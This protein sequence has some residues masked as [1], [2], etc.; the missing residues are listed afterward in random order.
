MASIVSSNDQ[1]ETA[2]ARSPV[3]LHSDAARLYLNGID[4]DFGVHVTTESMDEVFSYRLRHDGQIRDTIHHSFAGIGAP[5]LFIRIFDD[6]IA[7]TDENFLAFLC[8][9]EEK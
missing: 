2:R 1:W 9:A 6:L 4:Q 5:R 3:V 8:A 7:L